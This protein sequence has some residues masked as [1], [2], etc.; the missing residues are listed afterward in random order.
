MIELKAFFMK[1][2]LEWMSASR[3]FSFSDLIELLDFCNF[4]ALL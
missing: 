2:L 3:M 1:T 4:G